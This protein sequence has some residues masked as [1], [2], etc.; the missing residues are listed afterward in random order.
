M[1]T[2]AFPAAVGI[3]DFLR[4]REYTPVH[5]PADHGLLSD[6]EPSPVF[7]YNPGGR[8]P[9]LLTLEHGSSL[10]PKK[11]DNLGMGA[12]DLSTM[13]WAVDIGT[14]PLAIALSNLLDAPLVM[15]NYSRAVI[16]VNRGL[17]DPTCMARMLD[18]HIIDGNLA[19]SEQD[20]QARIETFYNPY[21]RQVQAM[22][23]AM[24]ARH[25]AP[26]LV[27]LHSFTP[28]P[29]RS[30]KANLSGNTPRHWEVAMLFTEAGAMAERMRQSFIGQGVPEEVIGMNEPYTPYAVPDCI[31]RHTDGTPVE[32]VMLEFR[33]N[34]LGTGVEIMTLALQS[35]LAI[36]A[37]CPESTVA[38]TMGSRR[39]PYPANGG[40][41]IV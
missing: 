26:R 30:L 4:M 38:P 28:N 1:S 5:A 13:H 14:W 23:E 8:C 11:L 39:R 25:A 24:Q 12:M 29:V 21:R 20:R 3:P 22:L 40:L 31:L 32:A 41:H 7:V 6:G 34:L 33:N 36:A 10:V 37:A 17:D 18:G 16:D 2:A 15:A 19:L 35:A 27:S 9:V